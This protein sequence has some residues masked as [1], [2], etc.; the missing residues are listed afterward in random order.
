MG[1]AQRKKKHLVERPAAG[2][3]IK[4]DDQVVL[5]FEEQGLGTWLG[6]NTRKRRVDTKASACPVASGFTV[7]IL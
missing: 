6:R 5:N 1:S 4:G 2:P 7:G 3:V